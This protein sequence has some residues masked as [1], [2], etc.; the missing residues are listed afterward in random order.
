MNIFSRESI[1]E[2]RPHTQCIVLCD[3]GMYTV[4]WLAPT[5][6]VTL[7]LCSDWPHTSRD[8]DTVFWLAPHITWPWYCVL[9]GLYNIFYQ[10]RVGFN[11]AN[12]YNANPLC[13][14][15][16]EVHGGVQQ[17]WNIHCTGMNGRFVTIAIPG[18]YVRPHHT[19]KHS[20]TLHHWWAC[21]AHKIFYF[22]FLQNFRITIV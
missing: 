11:D 2:Y 18:E 19:I 3:Q 10:V 13:K 20:V 4:F 22:E 6:H 21:R 17:E 8:P 7:I 1:L 12:Y 5:H 15:S 14:D 16:I 9:I